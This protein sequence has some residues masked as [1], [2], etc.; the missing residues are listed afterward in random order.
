LGADLTIALSEACTKAVR[1]ASAGLSYR[2]RFCVDGSRCWME[3][4]DYGAGFD[5]VSFQLPACTPTTA[6]A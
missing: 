4:R 5:P 6:A 2:V 1:H 3:V